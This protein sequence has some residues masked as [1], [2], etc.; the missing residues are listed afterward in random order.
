MDEELWWMWLAKNA[1]GGDNWPLWTLE[2]PYFASW[3]LC[4]FL[5][6]LLFVGYGVLFVVF[7]GILAPKSKVYGWM[8]FL[9]FFLVVWWR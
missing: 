4:Y 9:G 6:F 2:E 1:K 7:H 3:R 5:V 8:L